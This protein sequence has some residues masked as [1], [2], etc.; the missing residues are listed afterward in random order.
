[1]RASAIENDG[2][3]LFRVVARVGVERDARGFDLNTED[4]ARVALDRGHEPLDAL[5]RLERLGKQDALHIDL[6]ALPRTGLLDESDELAFDLAAVL[7]GDQAA[8]EAEGDEVR[9]DI[10]VDAA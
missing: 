10:R 5:Q 9:H 2:N 4:L 8:V 7:L 3:L 6:D 1:A